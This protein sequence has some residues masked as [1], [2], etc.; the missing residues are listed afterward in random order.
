MSGPP[1]RHPRSAFTA[2]T[3]ALAAASA[4]DSDGS[5][6]PR[7][8]N[9]VLVVVDTLRADY[10]EPPD[11]DS[12]RPRRVELPNLERFAADSVRFGTAFAH[13]PL[14][15]PSHAALFSA[16][17]PAAAGVLVNEQA[18]ARELPLLADWLREQGYARQA[19]VSLATLWPPGPGDGLD[20]GFARFVHGKSPISPG[21]SVNRDLTAALDGLAGQEPFFLF[22]H[23]AE[24]H[25]PY[26]AHGSAVATA[27]VT[28]NGRPLQPLRTSEWAE[29][30]LDLQLAPGENRLTIRSAAAFKVRTL[31]FRAAGAVL[32]SR[33][34]HSDL[35]EETRE[36][37][38]AVDNPTAEPRAARLHLWLHDV[39]SIAEM[40][41]RY[42]A[43]A[44]AA[45]RAFGVLLESLKS[46]G[47]YDDS[48]IVFTSD[49][50]EALGE[51]GVIGHVVHLHDELLHV[52]LM[53]KLPRGH[54]AARDLARSSRDLARLI[55]VVP[56]LLEVLGL[57]PLPGA[58]G[59]SLLQ[60]R[61][62]VLFAQ[63]SAPEAPRTLLLL[64][65][66]RTKLIY[67]VAADSFTMYDLAADP[68][69]TTDIFPK[70]GAQKLAWQKQ[71]R[72]LGKASR[73]AETPSGADP[74]FRERLKALGY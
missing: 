17:T 14:T 34:E 58:E 41:A 64:R 35:L 51:R 50:G 5:P 73:P 36:F 24:P 6:P 10:A 26:E 40:P 29:E 59:E 11:S 48:L 28:W 74:A 13:A 1:M 16:R 23:F 55:D 71:L 65:D 33:I 32:P 44:E 47:L 3:L 46:R 66:L 39:P 45:D 42:R 15:L 9:V 30:T 54:A 70:A 53:I 2:L 4:C 69:E 38:V 56:T 68:G 57:P 31:E 18:V 20:R 27:E 61:E 67:D 8:A 52:P 72:E 19:V 12:N 25:E 49:H 43:E 7:R 60:S 21:E 22:A 62:R 37:A 63:T